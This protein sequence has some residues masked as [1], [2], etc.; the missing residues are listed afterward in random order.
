CLTQHRLELLDWQKVGAF[1]QPTGKYSARATAFLRQRVL[2]EQRTCA[3]NVDLYMAPISSVRGRTYFRWKD[4]APWRGWHRILRRKRC[5]DTRW[6]YLPLPRLSWLQINLH[7]QQIW[8]GERLQ[9]QLMYRQRHCLNF[10]PDVMSAATPAGRGRISKLPILLL[11]E[12]CRRAIVALLVAARSA[13]ITNGTR[14]SLAFAICL[15][16]Q[17]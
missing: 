12:P 4:P 3:E 10:G 7:R 6:H 14:G 17:A 1:G 5:E 16:G 13:V 8:R 2:F 9:R 11:V 15:T